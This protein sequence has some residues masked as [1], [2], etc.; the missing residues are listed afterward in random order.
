MATEWVLKQQASEKEQELQVL[1]EQHTKLL[2]E[3]IRGSMA[4]L[5]CVLSCAHFQ[6]YMSMSV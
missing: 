4:I 1:R 2:E 5:S 6:R 3:T